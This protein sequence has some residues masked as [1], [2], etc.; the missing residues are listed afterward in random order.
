MPLIIWLWVCNPSSDLTIAEQIS[1]RVNCRVNYAHLRG[2]LHPNPHTR[3]GSPAHAPLHPRWGPANVA[4]LS[5]LNPARTNPDY[6]VCFIPLKTTRH[7]LRASSGRDSDGVLG[8][9]LKHASSRAVLHCKPSR[10][11]WWAI[12]P[13]DHRGRSDRRTAGHTRT[14][15]KSRDHSQLSSCLVVSSSPVP[16]LA[17]SVSRMNACTDMP[18]TPPIW[19]RHTVR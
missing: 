9:L 3:S 13:I 5:H 6:P 17:R 2:V 7:R 1:T 19:R 10:L 14:K 16:I 11:I 18:A 12:P 8:S 15:G 4:R